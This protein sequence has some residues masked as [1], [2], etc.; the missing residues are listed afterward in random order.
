MEGNVT[1]AIHWKSMELL[2]EN[3]KRG[4]NRYNSRIAELLKINQVDYWKQHM[5]KESLQSWNCRV[6]GNKPS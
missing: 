1:I 4:K 5:W 6:I 2:I 3:N